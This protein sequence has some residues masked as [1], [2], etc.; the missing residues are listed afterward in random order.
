MKDFMDKVAIVTG[1][2]TGVGEAI[3]RELF[4]RG[5]IVLITGRKLSEV[6]EAARQMDPSG[7]W[8]IP[9]QTEVKDHQSVASLIHQA[10]TQFGKLHYLVNNAGI[11]GPHNVSICDYAIEDWHN[12]IET[13]LSGVFFGMKF[14]IPA[15]IQSGG[16]AIVNL[17]AING[18]VGIAGIAPYTTAKHGVI[19]LTKAAALEYAQKGVRINAVGPG[20][21]D[22]QKM[23]MLTDTVHEYLANTHPM[24]RMATGKEVA[25]TVAFLLSEE[26]S[27]TTGAF[28]PID[29]GYTAQ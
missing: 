12:I 22:T 1:A 2:T 26:S 27:F 18:V 5:A 4:D 29:G 10:M 14:G 8:V 6:Q 3:A 13:D 25:K 20:Y 11:T 17:S 28:Y 16:G 7:Q 21:V 9:V 24:K 23:Q 19:G 15:I